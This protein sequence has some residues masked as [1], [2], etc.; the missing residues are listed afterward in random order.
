VVKGDNFYRKIG[1]NSIGSTGIT[2][3][4]TLAADTQSEI[5]STV[6]AGFIL[7]GKEAFGAW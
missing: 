3:K 1:E 7:T 2:R 5:F 4:S 6:S